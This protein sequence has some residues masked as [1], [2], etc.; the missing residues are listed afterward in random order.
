[1]VHF[2]WTKHGPY[3][4]DA[5]YLSGRSG[6]NCLTETKRSK[7]MVRPVLKLG[8]EGACAGQ[9]GQIEIVEPPIWGSQDIPI[10]FSL[11][12]F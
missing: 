5:L 4:R 6:L 3:E 11:P 2:S 9:V 8:N 7:H 10:S 12:S 1:M